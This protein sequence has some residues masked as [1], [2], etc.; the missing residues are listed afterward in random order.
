MHASDERLIRILQ[1]GFGLSE[2]RPKQKEVID[3]VLNRQH[4]LALLATG[5][6]KSVCYQVPSQV[7]PGI[8]LVISPLI[9]LMQDQ[10]EGLRR[11]GITNA[12]CLNSTIS[13]S[14]QLERIQS[15]K[16][17]AIK[18]VYVAPERLESPTFQALLASI[19]VSLIV[20][21]EAH[22]ISQ[23]G[24]DFRPQYRELS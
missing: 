16:C 8:T 15:I 11:R 17:G 14:E 2:F 23:W 7:L 6:G 19:Q 4:T 5:Y 18:L 20:V 24:Y 9:A 22:C 1:D 21:D 3:L 10:V 12:T 13:E